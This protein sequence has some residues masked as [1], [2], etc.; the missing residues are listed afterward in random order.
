M[1]TDVNDLDD[2]YGSPLGEA[3]RRLI[4]R[5]LRARWENCTGLSLLGYGY[6]G[7]YLERFR[8][9]AYRTLALMPARQGVI[10]WPSPARSSSALVMGDMLPLPDACIDRALVAH[11][12]ETAESPG[13]LLEE[14]CRVLAP[15]GRALLIVPSRRGVWARVD[16]TPFGQGQPFS[17]SQLRELIRD[18]LFSPV[19]WGEALYLPPFTSRFM[20]RSAL[21][22]ERIG[23]ALGLPF[24]G[25]H[26]VEA[27]KQVYRPVSVRRVL[28]PT[29]VAL[30]PAFVPTVRRDP[31]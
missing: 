2:F 21:P 5:I 11:G 14:I 1:Q 4:G 7:P 25:V 13:D 12:L 3:V 27:V 20:I 18:T 26:V 31:V 29:E 28:R 6:C 19:H 8:D 16:G 9:E 24:A 22:I 10:A 23:S 30:Q 17:K 15:D